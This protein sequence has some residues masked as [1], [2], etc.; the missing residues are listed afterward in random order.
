[1]AQAAELA[2]R[3]VYVVEGEGT[4]AGMDLVREGKTGAGSGIP[5]EW[6]SYASLDALNR[7]FHDEE[8]V[9]S[10]VGIQYFDSKRNMAENGPYKAPFDYAAVY[11]EAWGAGG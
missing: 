4:A 7:I 3:D 1:M 8:P 2:N 11:K 10:G 5:L 6:D 9:P